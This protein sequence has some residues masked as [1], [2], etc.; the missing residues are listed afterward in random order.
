MKNK[1]GRP[2]IG[3]TKKTIKIDDS[4]IIYFNKQVNKTRMIN[5]AIEL[6]KSKTV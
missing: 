2:K 6:H 4:N 3:Q 1:V 5:E